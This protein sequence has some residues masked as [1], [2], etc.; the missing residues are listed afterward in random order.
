MASPRVEFEADP[1]RLASSA[2]SSSAASDTR[3]PPG[4]MTE[5]V[6]RVKPGKPKG[7]VANVKEFNRLWNGRPPKY[8]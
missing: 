2:A 4:S 1:T 5:G 6:T 3:T 7:I 8:E